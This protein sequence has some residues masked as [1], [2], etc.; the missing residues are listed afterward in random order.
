MK[1]STDQ[2]SPLSLNIF[3]H[4]LNELGKARAN[5]EDIFTALR[6][7]YQRC[8]GAFA[9]TAMIAGFGILGFRDANGIRPLSLGERP[10]ATVKGATDYFMASESV[11]LSQLGFKNIRDIKPGHAV[12]IQKGGVPMEREI[13]PAKSYTPDMYALL[14]SFYS[15]Q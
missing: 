14:P 13:V 2:P 5:V 3:A 10:S 11:A 9:C 1:P 8:H 4:A 6:E 12:F 7:V 15:P